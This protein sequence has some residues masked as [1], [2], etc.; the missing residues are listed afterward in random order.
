[1]LVNQNAID[2]SILCLSRWP[3]F[4]YFPGPEAKQSRY[5]R[6]LPYQHISGSRRP[7]PN[8]NI[9]PPPVAV[10]KPSTFSPSRYAVWVNPLW[11][12]SLVMSLSCALWAT[13]LQQWARRYLDRSHP[14]RCSPE[15]RARMR[16]FFALAWTRWISCGQL[17]DCRRYCIDASL[18]VPFLWR[19]Y[20]FSVQCEP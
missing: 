4:C 9:T 10:V 14:P 1:M 19:V 17:K 5:L 12:L 20:H 3:P 2:R 7:E 11:F 16:A 13:S 8:K 15:K 6:T 18:A